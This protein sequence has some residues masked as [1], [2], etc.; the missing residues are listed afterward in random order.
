MPDLRAF[1]PPWF[2]GQNRDQ[3]AQTWAGQNFLAILIGDSW[4][5][6]ICSD[7]RARQRRQAEVSTGPDWGLKTRSEVEANF[8]HML[9]KQ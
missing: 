8:R 5:I 9:D 3:V 1:L 7:N 4:K 2:Q 6:G